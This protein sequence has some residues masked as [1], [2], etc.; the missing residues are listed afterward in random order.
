[1]TDEA[2]Q[3]P[4]GLARAALRFLGCLLSAASLGIGFLMIA[5]V[6]DGLHDR[7][8]RTHV[9]RAGARKE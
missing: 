6:G 7:I 8:A 5:F 4:I 3:G 2:G 9:V 1:M